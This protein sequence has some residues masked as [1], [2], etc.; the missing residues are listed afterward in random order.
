MNDDDDTMSS[1]KRRSQRGFAHRVLI[2]GTINWFILSALLIG[3]SAIPKETIDEYL[4]Q[5]GQPVAVAAVVSEYASDWINKTETALFEKFEGLGHIRDVFGMFRT[6]GNTMDD[7]HDVADAFH[8]LTDDL[9]HLELDEIPDSVDDVI[10]SLSDTLEHVEKIE[11]VLDDV[12]PEGAL[13]GI[14]DI[15]ENLADIVGGAG[16]VVHSIENTSDS[17]S[18]VMDD[19]SEL[20]HDAASLNFDEIPDSIDE[21]IESVSVVSH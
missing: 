3:V 11:D 5:F 20:I 7:L 4:I 17:V 1:L 13:D 12:L 15:Q 18:D 16:D 9:L 2:I 14:K 6:F 10:D 19:V 8:D 21:V